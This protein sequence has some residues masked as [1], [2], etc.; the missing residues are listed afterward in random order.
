MNIKAFVFDLDGVIIN[1]AVIHYRA[2]QNELQKYGINFTKKENEGLK[3]LPRL[4]TLKAILKL[5]N[6]LD[7]FSKNELLVISNAKNLFYKKLIANEISKKD[8]LPGIKRFLQLA[9]QNNLKLAI[10]SSSHNAPSILKKLDLFD[11]FD[12]IV[13][14]KT[15]KNG[16][17]APDIFI[18]AC[19]KVGV[20]VNEAIGF[21]DAIEGVKGLLA[22]NIKTVAITWGVKAN[23]D[24]VALKITNTSELDFDKIIAL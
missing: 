22:A 24:G 21:E 14:P 9:K 1:T 5:K 11:V 13:D 8:I 10:A 17:P 7:Y 4:A 12:Y 16:K 15:I 2:W 19:K 3:G 18:K 20:S 23:W 6:K